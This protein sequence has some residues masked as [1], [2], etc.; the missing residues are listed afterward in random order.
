MA[1][2]L[3]AI[4]ASK[5]PK[6]P[7]I[8]IHGNEGIGKSTFFSKAPKPLF[9]QTEDGLDELKVA[10]L[11]KEGTAKSYAYVMEVITELYTQKHDFKTIVIDSAD[12]LEA[13]TWKH[14]A[15]ENG[16][17]N[18]EAFGYGK[19]YVFAADAFRKILEGLNALRLSRSMVVG[20]TAHS[21]VKRFDDPETEPYDR[22]I[23]K[24]HQR[25]SSV[26]SE[27]CDII[28][29]A[30]QRTIVQTE[31]VGFDKTA[32]RGVA[33]GERLLWTQERPAFVA[34]NRYSLPESIPLE[35]GALSDCISKS[36]T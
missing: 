24:M 28:G 14:V 17:D 7:R 9:I 11:P 6:P 27:W 21:Q 4:K 1:I 26:L 30:S 16:K 23:L 35:W 36:L 20:M 29:Y 10:K 34:K 32:R 2:D 12:W 25:T 18:I 5:T 13:L 31:D 8:L 33:V 19:G 22:Y 3:S 15:E